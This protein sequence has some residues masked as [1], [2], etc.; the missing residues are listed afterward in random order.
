[1][2]KLLSKKINVSFISKCI[3]K[4]GST[5]TKGRVPAK[6]FEKMD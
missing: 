5:V 2:Y 4:Y 6:D 1:M 3:D